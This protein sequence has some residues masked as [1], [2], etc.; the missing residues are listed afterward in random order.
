MRHELGVVETPDAPL[1][2]RS[3]EVP[4][5]VRAA[6]LRGRA[7]AVADP[8]ASEALVERGARLLGRAATRVGGARRAC[9]AGA[10]GSTTSDQRGHPGRRHGAPRRLVGAPRADIEEWRER[11]IAAGAPADARHRPLLLRVGLLPR[12]GRHPL[13]A[14]DVRRRRVRGRRAG[15]DARRDARRC[16]RPTS[17]CAAGS[18]RC[19]RRC[20]TSRSGARPS[21][22][23]R[24]GARAARAKAPGQ[25]GDL[26]VAELLEEPRL[27]RCEVAGLRL[28]RQGQP[29]VESGAPRRRARRRCGPCGSRARAPRARRRCARSG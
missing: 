23:G 10:S 12:A 1:T 26:V 8:A 4:G 27:D 29:R 9:A 11:V 15:R 20:P 7:R 25:R 3:T 28:A 2:A 14:G 5:G 22:V 13:R 6:G 21:R 24:V 17:T 16:R 19:S 18:S